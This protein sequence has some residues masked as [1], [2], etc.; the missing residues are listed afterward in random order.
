MQR[1][2]SCIIAV[3]PTTGFF[4]GKCLRLTMSCCPKA[5]VLCTHDRCH[6]SCQLDSSS[7]SSSSSSSHGRVG[8]PNR[9]SGRI[10]EL[11]K[12]PRLN[13]HQ[14]E[15]HKCAPSLLRDPSK[16]LQIFLLQLL[17][18]RS[19]RRPLVAFPI[20]S[21][22]S[23]KSKAVLVSGCRSYQHHSELPCAKRVD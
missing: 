2:A 9:M 23:R 20:E 18:T 11:F 4:N 17:Y 21:H 1:L 15:S 22:R 3:I 10:T 19:R 16:C 8:M 13:N 12:L 6:S 14:R 5:M 7:S